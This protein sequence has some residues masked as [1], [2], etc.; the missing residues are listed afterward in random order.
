MEKVLFFRSPG[1]P[2]GKSGTRIQ[3]SAEG[4]LVRL[5]GNSKK[6]FFV[7]TDD[8]Q[9]HESLEDACLTGS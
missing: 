9:M 8:I 3:G 2:N 6:Y 7:I 5:V 4:C 1:Y